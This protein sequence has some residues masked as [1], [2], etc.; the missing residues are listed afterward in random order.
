MDRLS[1]TR[2]RSGRLLLADLT[3]PRQAGRDPERPAIVKKS[4][5]SQALLPGPSSNRAGCSWLDALFVGRS[6]PSRRLTIKDT[7]NHGNL[8]ADRTDHLLNGFFAMSEIAL[9]SA[10]RARLAPVEKGD[11]AAR[12]AAELGAEPTRFL[13]TVQ[14]GITSIAMLS[15]IVGEA[16]LAPPLAAKFE[17]WGATGQAALYFATAVVVTIV[18][19]FSIVVGELVPKRLG[20]IHAGGARL[21]ARPIQLLALACKPFVWLLT[22]STQ[23]LLRL[24]GIDDSRRSQVTEEEISCGLA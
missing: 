23:L 14:I 2:P 18:T 21:V 15:G 17:A 24:L 3:A 13:S 9:V 10:R 19:Y 5:R 22:L 11:S 1:H 6:L 7:E 16:A 12:V 4:G 8:R 20:Q